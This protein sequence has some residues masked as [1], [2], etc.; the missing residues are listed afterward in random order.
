MAETHEDRELKIEGLDEL[1]RRGKKQGVLT[2]EEIMDTLEAE[3]LSPEQIDEIYETLTEKGIEVVSE[4]N[5]PADDG[6][7]KASAVKAVSGTDS[8]DEDLSPPEG[9][10]LDD[11]VRLYLKEIGRVPLL[12]PEQEVA[13]RPGGGG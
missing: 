2:Y 11:P 7:V 6:R 10:A 4:P 8:V 3:D 9:I 1:I 13:V 12:T 5:E